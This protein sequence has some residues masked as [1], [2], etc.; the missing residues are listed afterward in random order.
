M[1]IKVQ[2]DYQVGNGLEIVDNKTVVKPD[3]TGN[4]LIEVSEAGVKGTVTLPQAFD[5]S[6]LETKI[7][8]A[9]DAAAAADTKATTATEKNTTQDGEIATLKQQ[10]QALEQAKTEAE[11]KVNELTEALNQ[12]KAKVTALEGKVTALENREDLHASGLRLDDTTNEVVLTVEGGQELRVGL[13][14][15]MNV[16]PTSQAVWD[17][18]KALSTFKADLL[19][20]LKGEEVQD[21]AG[22]TKGFLLPEA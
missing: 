13:G 5:P 20:V 12:E 22:V 10:A 3:N 2:H 8:E 6:A 21:F 14:K 11:T 17:E 4:V 15:F 19:T 18:I 7:Q 9:K 16:V 1:A